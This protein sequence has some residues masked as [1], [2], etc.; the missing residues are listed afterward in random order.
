MSAPVVVAVD[1][2]SPAARAG[3]APGDEIVAI[4]GQVPRDIIEYR[5]LTDDADPNDRAAPR[6]AG[7]RHHGGQG[8]PASRSAS[9]YRVRAVR[10]SAHLRQPLRV[11]LHLPIAARDCARASTSRTTTT[12]CRSSTATS[13]RSRA[14]PNP[15]SSASS[16]KASRRCTSASTRPIPSCGRACCATS[17]ARRAC[18][19]CAALLDAGIEVHGQIVVCPGVNDGD[20]VR[21][22]A[23]RSARRVPRARRRRR[24]CRSASAATRTSRR[25]APH[26]QDE[27][28]FVV[29]AVARRPGR[30]PRRRPAAAS[31]TRPTSTTCSP[32]SRSRRPRRTATSRSTRT[33][34]GWRPLRTRSGTAGSTPRRP[35]AS[36]SPS[37]AARVRGLPRAVAASLG[38]GE[39]PVSLRPRRN[40]PITILTGTYGAAVIGP[41]LDAERPGVAEVRVVP[42]DYFGGNIGVAGLLAGDDVA[43]V[44]RRRRARA[45]LPA[46]RR[47]PVER[48]VPRRRGARR[49]ARLDRDVV[50]RV[51]TALARL[52]GP[53]DTCRARRD[54]PNRS[55]PSSGGRTSASRRSSTAS[56]AGA[57]RS[58][59][60]ARA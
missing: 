29:D 60:N 30:L 56:S 34:S 23:D 59:R 41:L 16:T 24:P 18:A 51:A 58:S 48:P 35:A 50:A 31:F 8:R 10:P 37:T 3:L 25:C 39:S 53:L 43:A 17:A 36:S 21:R 6:R 9:K 15:I 14:S 55:S 13:R 45:P 28:A 40:A 46:A 22:H 7:A 57:R 2:E 54:E 47:V 4:A 52:R 1:P 20:G 19:G 32:A 11:L 44:D 49:A 38:A 5:L 26:T 42:N 27:A 33:A 12:G